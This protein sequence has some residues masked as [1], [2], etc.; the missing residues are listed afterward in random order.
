MACAVFV[1]AL[2][3]LFGTLYSYTDRPSPEWPSWLSLNTIIAIYIVLLKAGILLVCAEGLGQLK[4]TWFSKADRPLDDLV[5][6]DDA[7]RGPLGAT[8]LLWRL[9]SHH[10][11]SSFGALII[12]LCLA[13][14]P[15]AQQ[16]IRYYD[17]SI[18]VANATTTPSIP[19]TNYYLQ[20]QGVHTGAGLQTLNKNIMKSILEGIFAPVGPPDPY[21]TTGNCTWANEFSTVAW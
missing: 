21:C 7:T 16:I 15:F 12:I 6:Y 1:G 14:D 3:G 17:C 4:W 19:R 11:L 5:T 13:T 9:K 18:A 20:P 10:L 2:F 8:T